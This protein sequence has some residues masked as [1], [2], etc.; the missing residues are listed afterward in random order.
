MSAAQMERL[1]EHMARLR[2]FKISERLS[3]GHNEWR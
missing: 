3:T 2:L 1:H